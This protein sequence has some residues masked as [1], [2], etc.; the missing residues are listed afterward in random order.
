[1]EAVAAYLK[2]HAGDTEEYDEESQQGYPVIRSIFE[3]VFYPVQVDIITAT[4]SPSAQRERERER[5][6]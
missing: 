3:A 2:G 5:T 6:N 4:P 1:M